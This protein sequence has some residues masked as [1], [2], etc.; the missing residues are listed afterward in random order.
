MSFNAP[1]V[2]QK[3][4][5]KYVELMSVPDPDALDPTF[6]EGRLLIDI[7]DWDWKLRIAVQAGAT[8]RGG[9]SKGL[10]YGRDFVIRGRVRAPRELRG[11][12]ITVTLSPFGPKV[13][14]GPGGLRQ[15]GDLRI[16][17]AGGD[18]DLEATLMLPE[19]AIPATAAALATLWKNLQLIT[20]NESAEGA[21]ISHY[22]FGVHIHANLEA[23]ANAE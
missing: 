22:F 14:F 12:A 6:F 7:L 3:E 9:L 15:I 11:K 4:Q 10:T 21:E 16:P 5:N 13:K 18:C 17:T 20:R 1:P 2:A 19:D 23:W 8:R